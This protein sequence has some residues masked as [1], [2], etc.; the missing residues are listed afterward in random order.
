MVWRQGENTQKQVGAISPRTAWTIFAAVLAFGFV[1]VLLLVW[2]TPR[3]FFLAPT[4][5]LGVSAW[6][7]VGF[8]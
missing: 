3:Y 5:W 1:F 6:A 4:Y 7:L 8:L 2:A